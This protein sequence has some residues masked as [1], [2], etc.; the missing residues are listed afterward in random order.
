[1]IECQ[2]GESILTWIADDRPEEPLEASTRLLA[3]QTTGAMT[4]PANG[5]RA[6]QFFVLIARVLTDLYR[7]RPGDGWHALLTDWP[8][9]RSSFIDSLRGFHAELSS[10][11]GRTS[12]ALASTLDDA[13]SVTA[14]G[15]AWT[16]KRLI[17]DATRMIARLRRDRHYT[18]PPW[19]AMLEAGVAC[20]RGDV[21]AARRALEAAI[22]AAEIAEMAAYREA[23]RH[24]LS[25][26]MPPGPERD[27]TRAQAEDWLRGQGVV[28]IEPF[29][30]TL[31]PGI[32]AGA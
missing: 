27:R 1:M 23:A 14:A 31:C 17:G 12:I 11:R 32:R 10:M 26:L 21:A 8:G 25:T 2:S 24:A 4:W 29:V 20:L 16:R 30:A 19:A 7:G 5:Y 22:A 15:G 28:K 9:L 6:Q 18:A 3:Q 13:A